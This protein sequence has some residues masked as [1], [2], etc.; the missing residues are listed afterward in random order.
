MNFQ[1]PLSR[2]KNVLVWMPRLTEPPPGQKNLSATVEHPEFKL[3]NVKVSVV[4]SFKNSTDCPSTNPADMSPF[5][6]LPP[7]AGVA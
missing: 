6:V 2:I 4:L 5:K 1:Y 7:L 3:L